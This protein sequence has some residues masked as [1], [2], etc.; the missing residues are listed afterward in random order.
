VAHRLGRFREHRLERIEQ[1]AA[2]IERDPGV[3]TSALTQRIYGSVPE[4][5]M[6]AAHQSVEVIMYHLSETD[7]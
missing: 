6:S 3:T 7:A 4:G 2:E 1:V 5:L